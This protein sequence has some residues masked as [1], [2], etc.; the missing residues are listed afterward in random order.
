[1][2]RL[3]LLLLAFISSPASAQDTFEPEDGDFPDRAAAIRPIG[4]V[5][6]GATWSTS[7]ID[8]EYVEWVVIPA[9]DVRIPVTQ[10]LLVEAS[11]VDALH[12]FHFYESE[13]RGAPTGVSNHFGGPRFGASFWEQLVGWRY[14]VGGALNV[15]HLESTPI[16]YVPLGGFVGSVPLTGETL[17]RVRGG[18]NAWQ[19][20]PD[21]LAIVAHA[22]VEVDAAP[23]LVFGFELDVPLV[24]DLIRNEVRVQVQ[25][26]VEAAYRFLESSL[27]G[28]RAQLTST[29]GWGTYG[30]TLLF[31]P[32]LRLVAP[33]GDLAPFVLVSS[34]IPIVLDGVGSWAG[35]PLFGPRVALGALY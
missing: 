1:V 23:E 21:T 32:F 29:N 12:I 2:R 27:F 13:L 28:L 24:L 30:A 6:M 9:L 7:S 22:R 4:L 10:G 26:R 20:M 34:Q 8:R 5:E 18:W 35:S 17:P 16:A 3:P 19:L 14:E 25:T 11:F 31:E 33:F 15:P